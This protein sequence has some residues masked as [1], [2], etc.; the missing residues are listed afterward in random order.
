MAKLSP[1]IIAVLAI[2]VGSAPFGTSG[3]LAKGAAEPVRD[4]AGNHPIGGLSDLGA[5]LA[6]TGNLPTA[7][8]HKD[9]RLFAQPTP[10]ASP[11]PPS[12]P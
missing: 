2:T 4:N 8:Q 5:D 7:D 6:S 3:A 12:P 1:Q 10:Y 9:W 11:P